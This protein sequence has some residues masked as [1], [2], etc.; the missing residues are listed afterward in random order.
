MVQNGGGRGE[1]VPDL[2]L[3]SERSGAEASMLISFLN[4]LDRS[5]HSPAQRIAFVE[6]LL[7]GTYPDAVIVSRKAER[8]TPTDAGVCLGKADFRVAQLLFSLGPS[9]LSTVRAYCGATAEA[10]LLKLQ[11]AGYTRLSNSRWRLAALAGLFPVSRIVAFEAK[12]SASKR[13]LEQASAHRWFAH[14]SYVLLPNRPRNETFIESARRWNVGIWVANERRPILKSSFASC[15]KPISYGSWLLSEW[16]S[17]L[18][19]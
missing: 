11:L 15:G 10:S 8:A 6:P 7:D 16:A 14:E 9:C 4:Q 12:M 19:A 3:R 2:V 13:V 5:M 17:R 18:A 1:V